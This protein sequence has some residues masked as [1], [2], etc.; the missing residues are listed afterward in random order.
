MEE[1]AGM[2]QRHGLTPGLQERQLR[3]SEE[4]SK[5]VRAEQ[6]AG[7]AAHQVP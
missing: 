7:M 3:P 1:E 2:W 5:G 6:E 4:Q